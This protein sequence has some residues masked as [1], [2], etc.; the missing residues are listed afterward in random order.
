MQKYKFLSTNV[1]VLLPFM[2]ESLFKR[3]LNT[4]KSFF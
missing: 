2:D 1:K 4:N 3:C